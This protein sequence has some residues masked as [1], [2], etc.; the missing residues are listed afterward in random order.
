MILQ[1]ERLKDAFAE[2]GWSRIPEIFDAHAEEA[3]E[4]NYR[5][6]SFWTSCC[7]RK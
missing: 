2:F 3:A 4:H 5:I 6:S 1:H 7:M